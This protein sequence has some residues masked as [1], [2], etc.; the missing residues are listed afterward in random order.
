MTFLLTV[1]ICTR[2]RPA[3]LAR[4]IASL[5]RSRLSVHQVI[6]S[7]DSTN[8]ESR[9]ACGQYS[10]VNFVEGPRRGLC[11]NRNN[12]LKYVSGSH[13]AFIDDDVELGDTFVEKIAAAIESHT[14]EDRSRLIVSGFELNGGRL[15]APNDQTFFGYQKRRYRPGQTINT[16]V[17]NATVFPR[18]LFDSLLFDENLV[19]G[20]DE[21]DLATRAVRNGYFIELCPLAVN[22]HYPANTNRAYYDRFVNA[23]RLYVTFKRYY[24][25]E[26]SPMKAIAF[27]ILS[28]LQLFLSLLRKEP[29]HAFQAT[30]TSVSLALS[31]IRN[32]QTSTP[33]C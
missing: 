17:I 21:V 2:N 15:V 4:A 31:Y 14:P 10:D 16:F 25:T 12:A 13:V 7:D 6:V 5:R 9:E 8:A 33:R 18:T 1:C 29:Q 26:Q 19:Y 11:A 28:P 3:E 23:S 30:A 24:Y 32:A 27:A 22:N 20:S